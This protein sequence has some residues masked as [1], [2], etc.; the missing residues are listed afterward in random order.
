MEILYPKLK[1]ELE[2]IEVKYPDYKVL[3]IGTCQIMPICGALIECGIPVDHMLWNNHP[4]SEIPDIDEGNKY[5]ANIFAFTLRHIF[6]EAAL[7]LYPDLDQQVIEIEILWPKIITDG[8]IE[9][10][11]DECK[12]YIRKL[13]NKTNFISSKR[14]SFYISFIEPRRN[15]LGNLFPRYDLNNMAFFVQSLNIFIEK[16]ALK[17]G[18]FFLD[19]N[20]SLSEYGR[21]YYQ[22]DYLLPIAHASF[23][24]DFGVDLDH[25]DKRITRNTSMK[26]MYDNDRYLSQVTRSIARRIRDNIFISQTPLIIKL[27]ICDLDDTLWRGI[28]GEK[29]QMTWDETD[30]WPLGLAEALL[31]FKARGGML[32]ICSKNE[33]VSTINKFKEAFKDGLKIEDFASVKI[34]LNSKT[35][36]IQEILS[37]VNLLPQ[38]VLFIDDNPREIDEVKSKFPEM[39]YLSTESY[40]WRRKIIFSPLTQVKSLNEE[41][42][43]RTK[44]IQEKI[45]RD[46]SKKTMSREAWLKSLEIYQE[47]IK[48]NTVSHA[49]FPRAIEL[50]NK[51]NQFNTTGKRWSEAELGEYLENGGSI[52]LSILRD[53]MVNNGLIGAILYQGDRIDQAVLS[54]R[55]FG[56]ESEY[57]TLY[58]VV[59]EILQNKNQVVANIV[60]T[61]KNFACH[62][63]Y[64]KAG[65]QTIEDSINLFSI[66]EPSYLPAHINEL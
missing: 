54:C 45:N 28:S 53:K 25:A 48:I 18:A 7:G 42:F 59:S 19:I 36:N 2:K 38:N 17:M 22:D 55:V 1:N 29:E 12:R 57:L 63:F 4:W 60:D 62:E 37:E 27:I 32:A 21:I 10:F 23:I 56:L 8:K 3:A 6:S 46:E 61:T 34:N 11:F 5:V 24:H 52:M 65:F 35:E 40:D 20:E 31:I 41:A 44:S 50:I 64:T 30:G 58:K 66:S 16:K 15:Y 49:H 13:F 33:D 26:E 43:I 51:T 47:N 39:Y 14:L 9:D